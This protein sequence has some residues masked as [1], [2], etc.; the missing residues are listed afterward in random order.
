MP[1]N[2]LNL[3]VA[4]TASFLQTLGASPSAYS[5]VF[6]AIYRDCVSSFDEMPALPASLRHILS[7]EAVIEIPQPLDEQ[8][9]ADAQTRKILFMLADGNTIETTL[10]LSRTSAGKKHCAVCL[11][12][13]VGC[14]IGCPFCAT[15]RQGF[16]RNLTVGE[17]IGQVLF[18]LRRF[19]ATNETDKLTNLV[20]MGMGEPLANYNAV[21]TAIRQIIE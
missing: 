9:S 18:F 17:I 11:S 10:M 3:T 20:F 19:C 8:V 4:E 1:L 15:G 13:Q 2:L 14:A 16:T 21:M 7:Q 6:K 5:R 12:S